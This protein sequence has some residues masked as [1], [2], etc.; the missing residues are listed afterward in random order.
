[1]T[2][3]APRAPQFPNFKMAP[4]HVPIDGNSLGVRAGGQASTVPVLAVIGN[5]VF[6][7][8]TSVGVEYFDMPY[9]A[10]NI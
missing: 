2:D 4:I 10:A 6:H 8:L 1:M 3:M 9:T 7:A 5:A